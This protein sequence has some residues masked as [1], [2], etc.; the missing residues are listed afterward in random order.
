[1]YYLYTPSQVD[2]DLSLQKQNCFNVI[3]L[4]ILST[5][6]KAKYHC[7][8]IFCRYASIKVQYAAFTLQQQFLPFFYVK[9]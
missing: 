4:W 9:T 1:M 3:S 5:P 2:T 6:G 7:G 8:I